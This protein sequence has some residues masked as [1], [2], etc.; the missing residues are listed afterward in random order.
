MKIKEAFNQTLTENGD[1][2]YLSTNNQYLDVLFSVSNLRINPTKTNIILN[3][4]SEYDRL[5]AMLVRDPRFGLG[6]RDLGRYLLNLTKEEPENILEVGRADDIFYLGYNLYL[7]EKKD[8]K[9]FSFLREELSKNNE[10][11]KKW[12]PRKKVSK[13]DGENVYR[14]IDEVNAFIKCYPT[15]MNDRM[16]RKMVK[17]ETTESHLTNKEYERIEYSK[18]PSLAL[19]KYLEAF[20]RN[21]ESRFNSY[22]ENVSNGE[23]KINNTVSQPYDIALAYKNGKLNGEEANILFENL[24]KVNIPK[25]LTIVDNSGSMYDSCNSYLKAR[26]IG[27]YIAKNSSYMNNHILTF[28]SQPKLLELGNRYAEDII[29]LSSFDDVSNTDFGKVMNILK[30]VNEDLPDFLLVLSDMQFDQGS[31]QSKDEAMEILKKEN[32]QIKII[33]W[34]F[35]TREVTMP[36][37]DK[38][39]NI[40]ISGYN[41]KLLELLEI[42]FDGK[43]FLD[44][45]IQNYKEKISEKIV[46]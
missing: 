6:E 28:S 20:K 41:A 46:F 45:L 25:I 36:E 26:A 17:V 7:K 9:Y 32:H 11:V 24:P 38:Y 30:E 27:H 39:G 16:Y 21:D 23:A 42:G 31:Q 10:L 14:N 34:N 37:T 19:M 4:D 3:P 33:W 18:V 22:L 35:N 8:N 43:A 40:F 5:F 12:M 29:I 15:F 2:A 13:K 44:K 1:N